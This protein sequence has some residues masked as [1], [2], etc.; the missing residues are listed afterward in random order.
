MYTSELDTEYSMQGNNNAKTGATANKN[1]IIII[2][3]V[4]NNDGNDNTVET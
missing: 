2:T 1:E 4:E 3:M